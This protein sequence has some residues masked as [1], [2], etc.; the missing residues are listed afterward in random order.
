[1]FAF[2]VGK[3]YFATPT[4][5][6]APQRVVTCIKRSAAAVTLVD[7]REV[8]RVPVRVIMDRETALLKCPDGHDRFVSAVVEADAVD[9]ATAGRA[10]K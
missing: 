9:V 4:I 8:L 7:V 5:Q 2:S 3:V 1:M 10:V 6:G